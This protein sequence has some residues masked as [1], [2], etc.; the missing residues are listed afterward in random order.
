MIFQAVKGKSISLGGMKTAFFRDGTYETS[1]KE[2]I[3]TIKKGIG[4]TVKTDTKKS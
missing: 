4:V 2:E 3:A 1:N